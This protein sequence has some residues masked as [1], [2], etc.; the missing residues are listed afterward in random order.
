LLIDKY[1]LAIS[2]Y[3]LLKLEKYGTV[4]ADL[5]E[6]LMISRLNWLNEIGILDDEELNK[7]REQYYNLK[8]VFQ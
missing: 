8:Q 7:R 5:P 3:Y 1:S 4:D 6:K 2:H